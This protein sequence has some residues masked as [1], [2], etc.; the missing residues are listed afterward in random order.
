[1]ID[2]Y[3]CPNKTAV[4]LRLFDCHKK[5]L[6]YLPHPHGAINTISQYLAGCGVYFPGMHLFFSFRKLSASAVIA[7]SNGGFN[8]L[9]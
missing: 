7:W 4:K 5:V 6:R 3:I 9:S 1:M 2:I 8:S